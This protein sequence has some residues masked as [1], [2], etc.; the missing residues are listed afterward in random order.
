MEWEPREFDPEAASEA[1]W[2]A[3]HRFLGAR[4]REVGLGLPLATREHWRE[5]L[6]AREGARRRLLVAEADGRIVGRLALEPARTGR[7][8]HAHGSVLG[9]WRRR[10]LG[11]LWLRLALDAA[12]AAGAETIVTGSA[13]AD[14]QRFLAPRGFA[15][16]KREAVTWLELGEVDREMLRG[17][18]EAVATTVPDVSIEVVAPR[19]SDDLFDAYLRLNGALFSLVP[20]VDPDLVRKNSDPEIVRERL[21]READLGTDHV[22]ALARAGPDGR[23]VGMSEALWRPGA[24]DVAYQGLTGVLPEARGRG[25]GRALKATL[26]RALERRHPDLRAMWTVNTTTNAAMLAINDRLGFRP[27]G[28]IAS[29]EIATAALAAFFGR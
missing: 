1:E 13:E 8:L 5:Y 23:P 9:P 22:V 29:Y 27:R 21:D 28:H 6:R 25:V 19:V 20:D 11:T 10:G 12:E 18:I 14:G 16:T 24:D 4:H 7:R 17:W 26:V 3:V 2:E 15:E